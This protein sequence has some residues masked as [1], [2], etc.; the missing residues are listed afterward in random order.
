MVRNNIP[1]I[2]LLPRTMEMKYFTCEQL[3]KVKLINNLTFYP[4]ASL[5]GMR[6]YYKFRNT[7]II[8]YIYH[9]YV[10]NKSW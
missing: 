10:Y 1:A 6:V 4:P 7:L 5:K 3:K 9:L 8:P 2:L